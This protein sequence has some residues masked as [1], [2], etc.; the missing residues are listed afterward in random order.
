MSIRKC[1]LSGAP[2]TAPPG[3]LVRDQVVAAE[4]RDE[5]IAPRADRRTDVYG[6]AFGDLV[7]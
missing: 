7:L 6:L 3:Q 1:R 5:L 2:T 4:T